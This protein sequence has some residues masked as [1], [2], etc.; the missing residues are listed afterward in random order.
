MKLNWNFL[1]G[2]GVQNRRLSMGEYGYFL[3]LHNTILISTSGA[4]GGHQRKRS[5]SGSIQE[6]IRKLSFQGGTN[7]Q[8]LPAEVMHDQSIPIV[9]IS[10]GYYLGIFQWDWGINLASLVTLLLCI[11][12]L[13]VFEPSRD[14]AV[15]M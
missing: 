5:R 1:G 9:P 2:A 12:T 14:S 11:Q 4:E 6:V 8:P 15:Y 13:T 10:P 3:E 7:Y